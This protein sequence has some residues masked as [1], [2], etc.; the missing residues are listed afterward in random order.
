MFE[1]MAGVG[2]IFCICAVLAL[3]INLLEG[4]TQEVRQCVILLCLGMPVTAIGFYG[5]KKGK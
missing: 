4:N 2:G 5:V 3:G 1:G